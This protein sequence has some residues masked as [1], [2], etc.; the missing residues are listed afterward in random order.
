MS[1][2]VIDDR[3]SLETAGTWRCRAQ[4]LADCGDPNSTAWALR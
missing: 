1:L 4:L 2:A 3:P